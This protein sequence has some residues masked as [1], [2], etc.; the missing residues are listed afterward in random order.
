MIDLGRMILEE[1]KED[2]HSLPFASNQRNT[3]EG[4]RGQRGSSQGRGSKKDGQMR[5]EG[6]KARKIILFYFMCFEDSKG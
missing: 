6:A 3:R 2:S 4:K 1:E 5:Q